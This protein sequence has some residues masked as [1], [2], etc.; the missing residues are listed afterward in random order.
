MLK[1]R[2]AFLSLAS[3]LMAAALLA[4]CGF[5]LRGSQGET[6]LPFKTMYVSVSEASTLGG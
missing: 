4:G 5:H 6:A 1:H 2:R 3:G